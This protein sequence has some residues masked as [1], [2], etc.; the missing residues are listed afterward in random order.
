MGRKSAREHAF[1][2]IYQM[3]FWDMSELD[4]VLEKY[5]ANNPVKVADRGFIECLL[6]GVLDNIGQISKDIDSNTIGWDIDRIPSVD[7]A[8]MCISV[9]EIQKLDDIPA[10]ASINEAVELAKKYG[11]D[12][13]AAVVNGVLGAINRKST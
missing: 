13:S 11:T 6:K 3:N 10:A 8:I 5:Y 2:L 4:S 7:R 9:Y 12:D 1:K